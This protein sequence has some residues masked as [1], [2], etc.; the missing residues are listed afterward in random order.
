MLAPAHAFLNSTVGGKLL[1]HGLRLPGKV[2]LPECPTTC[3]EFFSN[4][5]YLLVNVI[6]DAMTTLKLSTAWQLAETER[7]ISGR[8]DSMVES[9]LSH[10]DDWRT[11]LPL[12]TRSFVEFSF[13][14]R[15]K[16][17]MRLCTVQIIVLFCTAFS[18]IGAPVASGATP[19]PYEAHVTADNIYLR[20]GPSGDYY[21]TSEL[22]R[23]DRVEVYWQNEHGW[24]AVRPPKNS[25]SWLPS[26]ALRLVEGEHLAEVVQ[27]K[28]P[29]RI[30][31]F[32]SDHRNVAQVQLDP[33]AMVEV[34][35]IVKDGDNRWYCLLY[36]SPSPRDGL[37]SRMPSSA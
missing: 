12:F 17:T 7:E 24:L 35:A 10:L 31:S 20:S 29:A 27:A 15:E 23:G 13:V 28:I 21:P 32:L 25:F 34:L 9:G 37:L 14:L 16:S 30:G 1:N 19:F 5:C 26:N 2:S 22:S 33:G 4:L 18:I 8:Q 36:T 6:P 3:A 11:N